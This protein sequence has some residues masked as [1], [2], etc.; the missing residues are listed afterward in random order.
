M[1]QVSRIRKKVKEHRNSLQD[2]FIDRTS[3]P[4]AK[5]QRYATKKDAALMTKRLVASPKYKP[6]KPSRLYV[7][8]C[9]YC[10]GWHL[11]SQEQLR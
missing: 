2:E 1:N 9:Q 3:M 10:G 7:Y 5:K 8:K 6:S 11:T 4:C